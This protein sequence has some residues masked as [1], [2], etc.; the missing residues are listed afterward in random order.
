MSNPLRDILFFNIKMIVKYNY[1]ILQE[2]YMSPCLNKI[3]RLGDKL[4][5]NQYVDDT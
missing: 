3:L 5:F 2:F 1:F 4:V